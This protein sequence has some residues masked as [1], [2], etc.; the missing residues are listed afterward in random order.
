MSDCVTEKS[1]LSP[2]VMEQFVDEKDRDYLLIVSKTIL[3][4][5][6]RKPE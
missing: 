2:E 6:V 1:L 4:R 5:I 3:T